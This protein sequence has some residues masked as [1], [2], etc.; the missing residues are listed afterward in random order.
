[1]TDAEAEELTLLR[2]EGAG[3]FSLNG[4]YLLL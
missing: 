3:E 2:C 4:S 1:L